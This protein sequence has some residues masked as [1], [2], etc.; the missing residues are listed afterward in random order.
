MPLFCHYDERKYLFDARRWIEQE[1]SRLRW[2]Q[3]TGFVASENDLN[4][5]GLFLFD[6]LRKWFQ[7][8]S[9][10]FT[11]SYA[12]RRRYSAAHS[13]D[14]FSF[15]TLA[16]GLIVFFFLLYGRAL[17]IIQKGGMNARLVF[18]WFFKCIKL[19]FGM[20]WHH[21]SSKIEL[22][23]FIWHIWPFVIGPW[24]NQHLQDQWHTIA[25][26]IYYY[27][28]IVYNI[29]KSYFKLSSPIL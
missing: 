21:F 23:S 18:F 27:Y 2:Q 26:Y 11:L 12:G 22:D 24:R 13:F 28:Y 19:L 16:A 20:S 6:R 7:C 9:H 4:V 10:L 14:I 5:V 8:G 15:C 17:L 25:I 3:S 1:T 29:R